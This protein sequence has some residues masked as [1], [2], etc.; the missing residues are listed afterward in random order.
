M[1]SKIKV[2]FTVKKYAPSF[3]EKTVIEVDVINFTSMKKI[4]N[5]FKHFATWN[6]NVTNYSLYLHHPCMPMNPVLVYMIDLLR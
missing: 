3:K 5:C 1:S 2:N 4:Q 6:Q